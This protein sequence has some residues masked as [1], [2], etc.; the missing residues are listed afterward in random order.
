MNDYVDERF[1]RRAIAQSGFVPSFISAVIKNETKVMHFA[2]I[3]SMFE[4]F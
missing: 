3:F 2:I 1:I 4:W